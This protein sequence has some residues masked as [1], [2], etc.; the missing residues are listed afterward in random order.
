MKKLQPVLNLINSVIVNHIQ[1]DVASVSDDALGVN[2]KIGSILLSSGGV[3]G[4]SLEDIQVVVER[5]QLP[6]PEDLN[7]YLTLRLERLDLNIALDFWPK[8]AR[9]AKNP[10]VG[11]FGTMLDRVE[12]RNLRV[13]VELSPA[14]V[15]DLRVTLESCQVTLKDRLMKEVTN[16]NLEVLDFDLKEK[17]KKKALGAATI[18][19]QDLQVRIL[20]ILLNRLLEAGRDRIPSIAKITSIEIAL[21][22]DTL[23]LAIKSGWWFTTIPLGLRFSTRN[24]LL[25]VFIDVV[26]PVRKFVLGKVHKKAAGKR[27]LSVDGDKIWID[28]WMKAPVKVQCKMERFCIDSGALVL[29]FGT[30]A[31]ALPPPT[32]VAEDPASPK[33][34]AETPPP[35]IPVSEA[36]A[37]GAGSASAAPAPVHSDPGPPATE[38]ASESNPDPS[39]ATEEPG[40]ASPEPPEDNPSPPAG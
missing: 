37:T 21:N 16:L 11:K 24:N 35:P 38:S 36:P 29:K 9:L 5:V 39:A 34:V 15:V 32:P 18:R 23:R 10:M 26:G 8:A 13:A 12:V 28:P 40:T 27:E 2:S 19:L 17:D 3:Q 25:G 7:L 6:T 1:V 14:K 31:K 30:L 4:L 33:P 20:E 22:E